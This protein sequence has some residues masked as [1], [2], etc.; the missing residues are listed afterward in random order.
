M[1]NSSQSTSPKKVRFQH[2][3]IN[4]LTSNKSS[5][6]GK[7]YKILV[8]LNYICLFVGSVSSSLLLKFY[9]N[10]KGSN[11]WLSTWV[12]SAGFPLLLLPIYLPYHLHCFRPKEANKRR[13]P[14]S[15]FDI[16]LLS[17]SFGVGLMLGVSNLCFSWGS[18]YLPLSTWSLVLSS[19]L[20][21]TLL[22]SILIVKQKITFLNV[23]CVILLTLGC[24]LLAMNSSGDR[25]EGLTREKYLIGFLTTVC[26]GLL[27]ALYLP[28]MEKIYRKVDCYAM[29]M[30]MQFLMELTAT[31]LATAGMAVAGGFKEMRHESDEVFDLGPTRYW[32]T[33]GFNVV[34][35]QLSFMG[36]AGMVFLTTSLTGGICMTA[37]MAMNVL[38][39]VVVYGDDFKGPKVVSTVLCLWGFCSYVYGMYVKMKDDNNGGDRDDENQ[40]AAAATIDGVF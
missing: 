28:L 36:A 6:Y 34:T 40:A 14:F 31:A 22:L 35:W 29:V 38:G 39:G 13:K 33:V 23:N 7:P 21:F 15:S 24:V 27:F 19:Q 25:P 3:E 17:L 32:L 2:P 30:E 37:L 5:L 8:T 18:S 26:A 12:Q 4:W 9:F 10:H 1:S 16:K 20:A 11:L